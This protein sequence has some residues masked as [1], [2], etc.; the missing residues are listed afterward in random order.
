MNNKD[1]FWEGVILMIIGAS[2]LI[3]VATIEFLNII[4][5]GTPSDLFGTVNYLICISF[6]CGSLILFGFLFYDQ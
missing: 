6:L 2:I 3:V 4:Y 5:N 1:G